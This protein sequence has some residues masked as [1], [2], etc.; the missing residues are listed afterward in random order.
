MK[1][2]LCRDAIGRVQLEGH[3]DEL[4][5][6]LGDVLP[7]GLGE[8][9]VAQ[10]DLGADALVRAVLK[11]C[12]AT[13]ERKQHYA[14]SPDVG[15]AADPSKCGL[16]WRVVWDGR[17]HALPRRHVV[18]S[19]HEACV[20]CHAEAGRAWLCRV[21]VFVEL[22]APLELQVEGEDLTL[23][24]ARERLEESAR[25]VRRLRAWW[26]SVTVMSGAATGALYTCQAHLPATL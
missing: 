14:C 2:L 1:G 10:T 22:S 3:P 13:Q 8:T 17:I 18:R 20:E 16:G 6:A 9:V 15:S 5:G 12:V 4:L 7:V 21:R 11:R 24:H 23:M 25:N 19:V 26:Q